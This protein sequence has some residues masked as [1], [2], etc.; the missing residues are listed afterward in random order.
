MKFNVRIYV[1]LKIIIKLLI[2]IQI[3]TTST[4]ANLRIYLALGFVL[5]QIITT[6]TGH[7]GV[8][9][10]SY[11]LLL[12]G[13]SRWKLFNGLFLFHDLYLLAYHIILVSYLFSYLTQFSIY[14]LVLLQSIL[15][16]N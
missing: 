11:R 6:S 2:L 9:S 15:F 3:I 13:V 1:F 7:Y 14:N 4:Y 5:I 16:F 10:L 12:H 8:F